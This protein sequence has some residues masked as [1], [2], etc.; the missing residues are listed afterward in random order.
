MAERPCP[1]CKKPA[2]PEYR[3]FCTRR[4][5]DVDLQRWFAGAYAV[6]AEENE[7]SADSE[8]P[9]GDRDDGWTG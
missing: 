9:R 2:T 7:E 3:P 4:C 5:A 6:P 8:A 1:V